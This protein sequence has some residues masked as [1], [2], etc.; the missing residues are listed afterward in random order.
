MNHSP[1]KRYRD[2]KQLTPNLVNTICM[3]TE[4]KFIFKKVNNLV[5]Y[6]NVQDISFHFNYILLEYI[7]TQLYIKQTADCF[8]LTTLHNV[9]TGCYHDSRVGC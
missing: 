7:N 2:Q 6:S 5:S 4:K 8:W 1:S 9:D 3:K